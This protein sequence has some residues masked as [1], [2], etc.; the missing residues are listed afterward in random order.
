MNFKLLFLFCISCIFLIK[1]LVEGLFILHIWGSISILCLTS[2]SFLTFRKLSDKILLKSLCINLDCIS[3][4]FYMLVMFY[5]WS[6]CYSRFFEYSSHGLLTTS[7]YFQ[8]YMSFLQCLRICL[9]SSLI[10]L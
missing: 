9:Q 3:V 5:I 7:Y 8:V 6:Q 2:I 4:T 10:Y 1:G